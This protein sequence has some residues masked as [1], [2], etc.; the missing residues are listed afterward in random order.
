MRDE[1]KPLRACDIAH[2]PIHSL[3]DCVI[4]YLP[5]HSLIHQT[6]GAFFSNNYMLVCF[7]EAIKRKM[8]LHLSS[9]NH[10]IC[11]VV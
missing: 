11:Q 2:P 5:I 3:R 6:L 4:A 8:T 10:T 1:R 9:V 7:K